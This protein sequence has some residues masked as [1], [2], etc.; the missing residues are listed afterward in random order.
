[1]T[2]RV[3]PLPDNTNMKETTMKK[4]TAKETEG[5]TLE[6][7]QAAMKNGSVEVNREGS[8]QPTADQ[9]TMGGRYGCE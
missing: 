3:T 1:M 2:R 6:Q 9:V 4:L 5:M 8:H 7:F